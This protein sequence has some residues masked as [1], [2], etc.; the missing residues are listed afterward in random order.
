MCEKRYQNLS[1]VETVPGA[2]PVPRESRSRSYGFQPRIA[3]VM[4][5]PA[6]PRATRAPVDNPAT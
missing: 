4:P 3:H 1:T 6:I 2:S 5:I